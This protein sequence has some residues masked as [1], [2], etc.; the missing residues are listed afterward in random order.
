[1]NNTTLPERFADCPNCG[2]PTYKNLI[3]NCPTF[4]KLKSGILPTKKKLRK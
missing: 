2:E 4:N 1:M 3:H